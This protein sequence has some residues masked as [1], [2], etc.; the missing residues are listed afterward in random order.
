MGSTAAPQRPRGFT[1]IEM[2]IV[3]GIVGILAAI[4]IPNYADYVRR[5]KIID[6]TSQLANARVR[7]EQWFLD[8]HTYVGAC[9]DPPLGVVRITPSSDDAFVLSC[10]VTPSATQ[11]TV[12]ATGTAG[13]GMTD[14]TYTINEQNV[15][16]T[17][18]TH[19]GVTSTDCW[20]TRKDGSCG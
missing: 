2:M 17:T 19:W 13:K 18:A 1:L 16:A 6:A 15:K 10:P 4:A 20:I 9:Q 12:Q 5:G 11:Y 7:L 3:V 14:F 8:Q